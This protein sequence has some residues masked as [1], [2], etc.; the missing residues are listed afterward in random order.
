MGF[1]GKTQEEAAWKK[2]HKVFCPNTAGHGH[3]L[4]P[5]ARF[6][7]GRGKL[8]RAWLKKTGTGGGLKKAGGWKGNGA[9]Q[10]QNPLQGSKDSTSRRGLGGSGH[11]RL[12]LPS[13]LGFGFGTGHPKRGWVSPE[14]SSRCR[15][16]QNAPVAPE[17]HRAGSPHPHP[18]PPLPPSLTCYS[19]L[20]LWG[21]L[22]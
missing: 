7:A 1:G 22:S 14:P 2:W 6:P 20:L 21:G 4:K 12:H 17:Q 10:G 13:R 11:H 16:C 8:L 18:P 19:L 9:K 5:G 3:H 15:L